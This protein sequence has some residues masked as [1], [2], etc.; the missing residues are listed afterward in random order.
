M[1]RVTTPGEGPTKGGRVREP[2]R[3]MLGFVLMMLVLVG[4]IVGMVRYVQRLPD[5]RLGLA[6][7][8]MAIVAI[9][10]VAFLFFLRWWLEVRHGG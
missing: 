10:W 3:A 8:V 9:A 2:T 5:D 7:Y 6:L 4:Q 1:W